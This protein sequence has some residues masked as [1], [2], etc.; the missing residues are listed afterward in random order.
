MS[1]LPCFS[2]ILTWCSEYVFRKRA[3]MSALSLGFAP[4]KPGQS[5][6]WG[7][8]NQDGAAG[9]GTLR[10]SCCWWYQTTGTEST[11]GTRLVS[12]QCPSGLACLLGQGT[13]N[14]AGLYLL[15]PILLTIGFRRSVKPQESGEQLA[16]GVDPHHGSFQRGTRDSGSHTPALNL[17]SRREGSI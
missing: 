6:P 3:W 7:Q 11:G 10:L 13:T 15:L 8:T 14:L 5:Q 12:W 16:R 9:Y 1:Y 4:R 17:G 2:S